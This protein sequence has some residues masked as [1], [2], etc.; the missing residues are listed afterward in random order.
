MGWNKSLTELYALSGEQELF[1]RGAKPLIDVI[2]AYLEP[3]SKRAASALGAAWK[4]SVDDIPINIL[5]IPCAELARQ[6]RE[7][8]FRRDSSPYIV[9]DF[10][11][12]YYLRSF[13]SINIPIDRPDLV[14]CI[15]ALHDL[16][17]DEGILPEQIRNMLTSWLNEYKKQTALPD[18]MMADLMA[19]IDIIVRDF[20]TMSRFI[21][22]HKDKLSV[23]EYIGS[24]L[25]SPY[26]SIAKPLDR[27]HN[28][29][30][31]AHGG[32]FDDISHKLDETDL[33]FMT[34][35]YEI[36]GHEGKLRYF[37]AAEKL[38]PQ[39][40]EAYRFLSKLIAAGLNMHIAYR[41]N[42]HAVEQGKDAPF[43][44]VARLVPDILRQAELPRAL[45]PLRSLAKRAQESSLDL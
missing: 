2:Q 3:P 13:A 25:F 6:Y 34:P 28:I 38:H 29:S 27:I 26:T 24:T 19:D 10:S 44:D 41:A 4:Y 42:R 15:S 12:I 23:E 40:A 37:E 7:G 5:A 31:L 35:I 17:E 1:D 32:N 30:T 8:K 11:Q 18:A 14:A 45:R 43:D 16:G 9:H 36:P 33:F 22:G 21:K 20:E 39:N